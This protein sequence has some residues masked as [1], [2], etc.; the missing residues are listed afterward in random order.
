MSSLGQR[1]VH[2][3]D[4]F[5]RRYRWAGFPFAVVKKYGDDQAGYLA[6]LIAYYGFF[7]VFPLMLVFVSVLG[8]V[9]ANSPQLRQQIIDSA[10]AQFP[11]V[12]PTIAEEV[13]AITG[14]AVALTVGIVT[15]LWAGLGV[16]QATQNAM[17]QIWEV[18]R[19]DRP[20]FFISRL[21]SLLM[22]VVLGTMLLASTYFSGLATAR[23]SNGAALVTWRSGFP[24]L[25]PPS[26]PPHLSRPDQ[27]RAGLARGCSRGH[28]RRRP[29][30]GAPRR[31]GLLRGAHDQEGV[32]RLR[33]AGARDRSPRVDLP[34]RAAHA[35]LRGDQRRE[36]PEALAPRPRATAVH[37]SGPTCHASRD[38]RRAA[39][40]GAAITVSFETEKRPSGT[41]G[42]PGETM[43]D[44]RA[45]RG[46]AAPESRRV[47]ANPTP[48]VG[49]SYDRA[50][51]DDVRWA[52]PRVPPR[53]AAVRGRAACRCPGALR[54]HAGPVPGDRGVAL[55]GPVD[56]R[57]RLHAVRRRRRSRRPEPARDPRI[58]RDRRRASRPPDPTELHR[59][60]DPAERHAHRPWCVVRWPGRGRRDPSRARRALPPS[61]R[62]GR[63]DEVH[64]APRGLPDGGTF[65]H[66]PRDTA[67]QLPIQTFTSLDADGAAV[68]PHTLVV[69]EAGSRSPSSTATRAPIS[70]GPSATRS[71]R[72]MSATAPTCATSRSRSGGAA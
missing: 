41:G 9:L 11:I 26:L 40:S 61:A 60:L 21:R 4:R 28:H 15:A 13:H 2:A 59:D 49:F 65:L 67:I 34:R 22:L 18:P 10:L 37:G 69:V 16:V 43:R 64:G 57:T 38:T 72:S 17:N 30:D 70:R 12:G 32:E 51:H 53:V 63:P 55:H 66:V 3:I 14:D 52:C 6:A 33:N 42:P 19:K 54:F 58:R 50:E 48:Q 56:L 7:S 5:Q 39:S 1:T 47:G 62:S 27:G 23:G 25:Q 71:P 44:G 36:G 31:G 20:N 8:I 45:P 46:S 29:V 24:S 68:F 35:P